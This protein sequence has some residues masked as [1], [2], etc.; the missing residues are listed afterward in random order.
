LLDRVDVQVE[1]PPVG[2]AALAEQGEASAAVAAR[3]AAARAAQ[4]ERWAGS[5]W[6]VNAE[7][8]GR[9]LRERL[10]PD[11]RLLVAV[12]RAVDEGRLT[13][14]GADRVLRLAWTVAD[15]HGRSAPSRDDVGTAMSLRTRGQAGA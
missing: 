1:V 7:V 15:T 13:L 5:P 3:V 10:R 9:V 11:P 4:R 14:R 12:D 6:R 8:P 2:R